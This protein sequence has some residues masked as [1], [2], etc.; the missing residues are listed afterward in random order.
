VTD[1]LKPYVVRQGDT[2]MKLAAERGLVASDVWADPKNEELRKRRP[3]MDVLA[4]GD[5]LYLPDPPK[6]W[7]PIAKGTTNRYKATVPKV[8]VHLVIQDEEGLPLADAPCVIR[9]LGDPVERRTE[10][11]GGLSI[12]VPVLLREVSVELPDHGLV[13][14]VRV[15]DLDPIEERSGVAMRLAHLGYLSREDVD[16]HAISAFQAAQGLDPTGEM[17][18][19]TRAALETAHGS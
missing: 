10:A 2:L 16:S 13:Y 4:P 6:N 18:E 1:E 3:D 8:T 12:E 15:G 14:P 19:T 9:G 17:D 7:L 11:D 5:V